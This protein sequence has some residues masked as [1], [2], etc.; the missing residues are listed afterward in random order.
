MLKY[1]S[2][3]RGDC[4]SAFV[5]L[6]ISQHLAY[7]GNS[8][9]S[10]FLLAGRLWIMFLG[11]L[12]AHRRSLMSRYMN[13][14]L[15]RNRCARSGCQGVAVPLVADGGANRR[16]WLPAHQLGCAGIWVRHNSHYSIINLSSSEITLFKRAP[17]ISP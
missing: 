6:L 15:S 8:I 16:V 11:R 4:I 9:S 5:F 3:L 13:Y 1:I 7:A 12:A 2:L 10:G 17:L 14:Q